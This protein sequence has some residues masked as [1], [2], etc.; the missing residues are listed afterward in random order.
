MTFDE[1]EP[2]DQT[3]FVHIPKLLNFVCSKCGSVDVKPMPIFPPA[4][5]SSGISNE[6]L[7][8]ATRRV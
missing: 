1:L 8:S 4:R 6:R 3:I 7:A 2:P 5:G